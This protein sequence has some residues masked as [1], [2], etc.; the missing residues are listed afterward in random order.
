MADPALGVPGHGP[1]AIDALTTEGEVPGFVS[2]S[3]PV[4]ASSTTGFGPST[5]P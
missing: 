3:A 1:M 4:L 2:R 5:H